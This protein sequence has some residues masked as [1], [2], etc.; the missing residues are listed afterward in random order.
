MH[1]YTSLYNT[2]FDNGTL[3]MLLDGRVGVF[4]NG[5]VGLG[6]LPEGRI[7]GGVLISQLIPM[8]RYSVKF[9]YNTCLELA[10]LSL[11]SA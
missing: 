5:I 7:G 9:L 1:G 8:T 11:R 3:P 4:A 6:G 2:S 10:V